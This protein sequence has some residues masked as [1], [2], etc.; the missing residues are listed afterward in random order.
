M[1]ATIGREKT[2]LE[3]TINS[4]GVDVEAFERDGYLIVRGLFG[5]D[6]IEAIKNAIDTLHARGK[7]EGCFDATV[8]SYEGAVGGGNSA[9]SAMHEDPLLRY[10][11]MMQPHKVDAT[12]L[13]YLLDD[14]IRAV[15]TQLF[16]NEPLA[17]QSMV[18]WKP[19]GSRGQALHQDN[20][21]LQVRPGN[22]IAAWIA[23]DP[24]DRENGG[25][26]VV[27]GSHRSDLACP[28]EADLSVS[29][30]NH[31]VRPPEGLSE[32]PVDLASGDCM[33]F[34]GNLIHGS[35]PN[36]SKD[37]MR[38]AFIGHYVSYGTEALSPWYQPLLTMDGSEVQRDVE[39]GGGPC[40]TVVNSPH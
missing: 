28:E 30:T 36:T 16:D 23:L 6:D 34:G 9:P 4:E 17:A 32:V 12:A 35:H 26:V 25:M 14:R 8:S 10:P 19:A 31:F 3:N 29:F 39:T 11:R 24:A 7:I 40:G 18:Y 1:T 15:L 38:R 37:R 2:A 22:C 27:P 33:F 5:A 13:R 21:Y 20:F